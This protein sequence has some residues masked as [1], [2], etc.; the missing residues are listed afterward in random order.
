VLRLRA[1]TEEPEAFGSAAEDFANQTA[2]EIATRLRSTDGAF[3]LGAWE[4]DLVGMVGFSRQ[5]GRKA[6]HNG[7]IWGMYVAPE[8]RGRGIGRMLLTEALARATALSGLEQVHLT[9][10]TTNAA[11]VGL[12]R[13]LG[14]VIYGTCPHALKLG[15]R[16]VDE[17]LMVLKV[18]DS[19][20]P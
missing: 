8:Q 9:V 10:V 16:Y 13:S 15:D 6:R 4:P 19:P 20:L 11:A 18:A 2:E 17:H 7:G 5:S 14:F 3:V 12:Y 1:L